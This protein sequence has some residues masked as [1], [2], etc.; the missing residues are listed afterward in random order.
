MIRI[1]VVVLVA[2]A[3]SNLD[4]L[5]RRVCG[6]GIIEP[7]EDCDSRAEHCEACAIR[8]ETT[9]QCGELGGPGFVC[10]ADELCHAPAGTFRIG[11][12]AEL[13]VTSYRVT[14]IDGDR[15]GDVLAQSQTAITV[16]YGNADGAVSSSASIQTPFA[17]GAAFFADLDKG[18][19]DAIM[20]TADGIVAYHAPFDVPA[21]YPFP[22]LVSPQM[23]QPLFT[24]SIDDTILGIVTARPNSEQLAIAILD[25]EQNVPVMLGGASLCADGSGTKA[26]LAQIDIEFFELQQDHLLLAVVV[27]P[28]LAPPRLCMVAIDRTGPQTFAVIPVPLATVTPPS[29]RPVFADVR[30]DQCPSLL[31]REGNL[32]R[33]YLPQSTTRP[34]SFATASRRDIGVQFGDPV[35]TVVLSPAIAGADANAIVLSTGIYTVGTATQQ[36]AELYRSDRTIRAVRHADLDRDGDVDIVASG[37]DTDDLDIL[38]RIVD[39][40]GAPGFLRYRLDTEAPVLTFLIGDY[41]GNAIPDVAYI[42]R[43]FSGERLLI[44]YGTSDQLLHGVTVGAFARVNSMITGSVPDATDPQGVVDDLVVL[45]ELPNSTAAQLALLHGS[46]QRTMLAF[47]DPRPRGEAKDSAFDGVA[48]GHFGGTGGGN[49]LMAIETVGAS[50]PANVWLSLGAMGGELQMGDEASPATVIRTCNGVGRN[51]AF[52]AIGARYVAWPI[53]PDHDLVVGFD[54]KLRS[55]AFDPRLLEPGVPATISQWERSGLGVPETDEL[56]SI[57]TMVLPDGTPRLLLSTIDEEAIDPLATG[58]VSTCAL[59][60]T[61]GPSCIDLGTMITAALG[62]P[63]VC[64]DVAIA[65]VAPAGRFAPPLQTTPDLIVLCHHMNQV[66]TLYRVST[67]L[68]IVQRLIDVPPSDALQ[69]GDVTGDGLDDIITLARGSAVPLLRIFPQ[70]SSRELT[71][72]RGGE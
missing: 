8:C 69:I 68:A 21:P 52:C 40:T 65:N 11:G 72:C 23:G 38:D 33:E 42:E 6:N 58:T 64:V 13:P 26:E 19:L 25:V 24:H 44:A 56:R 9:E 51:D 55:I 46:P 31:V 41:D 54:R 71:G 50:E 63:A 60:P 10:G 1:V 53:A 36:L 7:G 4:S 28:V 70:C 5:D 17:R 20:P 37:T 30:G 29:S 34:C 48:V 32:L 27:R 16:L 67:D 62:R 49:D 45:Y 61:A 3:C 43:R 59:D 22:S 12:E 15:I 47:F 39:P 57:A 18:S 2:S 35:G 14:D 66:D